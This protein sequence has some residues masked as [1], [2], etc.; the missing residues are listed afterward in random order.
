MPSVVIPLIEHWVL[1]FTLILVR[2]ATVLSMLPLLGRRHVP[3]T[4][5]IGLSLA[6]AMMWF[7]RFGVSTTMMSGTNMPWLGYA[8]A[9]ARE[10]LFGAGL[11]FALGLFLVPV[12]IAGAYIA[13]EM[14]LTLATMTDPSTGATS[15]VPSQLLE[16]LGVLLFFTLDMHHVVFRALH[17]SFLRI[18]VGSPEIFSSAALMPAAVSEAHRWGLLIAAPIGICLFITSIGM[19]LMMK[20]SPQFNLFSVGLSLRLLAAMVSLVIFLPELLTLVQ[21]SF[22]RSAAFVTWLTE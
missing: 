22:Y 9:V 19:A 20:A 16:A 12:Q 11:G 3:T 14:G 8:L 13:Q 6:L 18:P 2:V 21:R 1:A 7:G 17:A 10:V 5:K 4:V 15:S